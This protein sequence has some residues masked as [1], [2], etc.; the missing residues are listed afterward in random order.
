MDN[1]VLHY[2]LQ[3]YVIIIN[4]LIVIRFHRRTILSIENKMTYLLN[5]L[6]LYWT[7]IAS[8]YF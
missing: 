5:S 6:L 3:K 2:T 7:H 4:E 1:D 8:Y